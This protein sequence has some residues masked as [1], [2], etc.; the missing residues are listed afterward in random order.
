M[1]QP[2]TTPNSSGRQSQSGAGSPDKATHSNTQVRHAAHVKLGEILVK[3]G[4]LR[5]DQLAHALEVQKSAG[6]L[7]GSVLIELGLI[8]DQALAASLSEALGLEFLDLNK[9]GV[10]EPDAARMIPENIARRHGL[11]GVRFIHSPDT[12]TQ[13][14]IVVAMSDPSDFTALDS[15]RTST[16][17]EPVAAVATRGQIRDA[18][19]TAYFE[20]P[21]SLEE[22]VGELKDFR[23][24]VG[25]EQ[26]DDK[27]FARLKSEAGL[28]PVVRYVNSMLFEAA[29]MRASDIHVEPQE[30]DL[31][32]RFRIDGDLR[33]VAPPPKALQ[34]AIVSRLKII[35]G[36]D[37]AERRLPQDGRVKLRFLG[38]MIDV[39]VSTMPTAFGEKVVLRLLDQSATALDL[40]VLGFDEKTVA[41]MRRLIHSPHGIV[42][43]CGPTGCGK[44]TTLYSFLRE[45][46]TQDVNI[47]TVEDPIEYTVAGVNQTHVH[48]KIGLTFASVLRTML[49]QDPDIMMVGEMR[50]LETLEVGVRASL[51]GH[52]VLSTLHTNT[53]VSAVT[54]MVNMGLQPYLIAA[55][56]LAAL[57]QRLVRKVCA[58]CRELR[59]PTPAIREAL[60]RYFSRAVSFP[61]ALP[62]GCDNCGHTGY[63]GRVAV[64][65]LFEL[66]DP[67]RELISHG[68]EERLIE[69]RAREAGMQ[70]LLDSAFRK[71]EMGLTSVDEVFA[72]GFQKHDEV[73]RP[74]QPARIIEEDDIPEAEARIV[75]LDAD[76]A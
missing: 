8:N 25:G 29:R 75:D 36:L 31:R 60:E 15:I 1:P 20:S 50:D 68:A 45:L 74:A 56:L 63:K 37:I 32:V 28:A 46:N 35:S 2:A 10:V 49:R 27:D 57:S 19:S 17:L 69:Q 14:R 39:R 6:G 59:E 40:A 38:R 26:M 66:D 72:L 58:D 42:L 21:L 33:A 53:A 30:H 7:I 44:S 73:K 3:K 70:M 18:L 55:T 41:D 76:K 54:R 5:P 62:R 52:L 9:L 51:T 12:R 43:L 16:G 24:E 71:L 48:P 64:S 23:I 65:E 67:M 22:A 13:A 11:I 34:S 61:V 4:V 47:V